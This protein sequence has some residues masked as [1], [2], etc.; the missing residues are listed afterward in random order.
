MDYKT[1]YFET[2]DGRVVTEANIKDAIC[3]VTGKRPGRIDIEMLGG[4]KRE[5]T[6]FSEWKNF[7]NTHRVGAMILYR[8]LT[9]CSLREA[10]DKIYEEGGL[11]YE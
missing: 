2:V 10:R 8:A 9:G 7:V 3:D 4:I 5:I 6:D 11:R 1:R